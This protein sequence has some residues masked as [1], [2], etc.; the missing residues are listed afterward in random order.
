[1]EL[2]NIGRSRL[3]VSV[4]GLGCNNSG[5]RLDLAAT[6]A[7]VE[8]ALDRGITLFDT[9]DSYGGRGGPETMLGESLGARRKDIVL[10]SKF[11]SAMDDAQTLKGASRRYIMSAVEASLR[12]LR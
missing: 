4:G 1:M 3:R 8:R 10:A 11:S 9:S 7:V 12:R 5:M 6:R 2:R